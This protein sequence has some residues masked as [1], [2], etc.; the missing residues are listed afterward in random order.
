MIGWI[1][2]MN[3]SLFR[4]TMTSSKSNGMRTLENSS[5]SEEEDRIDLLGRKFQVPRPKSRS[6][7]SIAVSI[8]S[9]HLLFSAAHNSKVGPV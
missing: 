7:A 4:R 1:I 5:S 9:S 2:E 8:T 6:N 3:I